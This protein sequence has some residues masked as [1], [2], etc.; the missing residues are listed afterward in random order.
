M[1]R[2]L[3]PVLF[4]LHFCVLKAQTI[5]TA[6]VNGDWANASTWSCPGGPGCGVSV[7]IPSGITV[8]ITS[9]QNYSACSPTPAASIQIYINGTLKFVTGNKLQLPCGSQVYIGPGGSMQPGNGGGN[10]NY[11]EICTN[12][13]WSADDGPVSGPTAFC[14]NP[15]CSILPVELSAFSAAEKKRVVYLYWKT[16]SESGN[17]HFDIERSTNGID[18]EKISEVP[19][20]AANGDSRVAI[21]YQATD[22]DLKDPLYYY[23]LKQVDKNS[24]SKHFKII[25]VRVS[26]AEL[27]IYPNPNNGQFWIDVP[28]GKENETVEV[29]II[30][31]MS[32]VVMEKTISLTSDNSSGDKVQITPSVDLPKGIYHTVIKFQGAQHHSKL[33]VQ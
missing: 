22:K 18:F 16:E 17:D 21:E 32:R 26:A 3:I 2:L 33:V 19:S 10:S 30:D 9:Q 13:V 7:V 6:T 4:L 23:R 31:N 25:S 11:L 15:P 12:I 29:C 24:D 5:C 14:A 27:Y 28:N 1:T 8:T 20:K